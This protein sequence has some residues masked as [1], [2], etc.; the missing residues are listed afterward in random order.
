M[1]EI[2]R[3]AI[4]DMLGGMP[5]V[6]I[7]EY[8]FKDTELFGIMLPDTV[9]EIR[10]D[11]FSSADNLDYVRLSQSLE[12]IGSWAFS[13]NYELRQIELPETLRELDDWAF[14]SSALESVVVPAGTESVGTGTF[15][16][17]GNLTSVQLP[18]SCAYEEDSFEGIP[19]WG[20]SF[21]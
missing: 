8:A 14:Y 19:G 18:Q 21:Y 12:Y 20:I 6:A 11:A 16:N 15:K 4:P 13:F 1:G 17:C 3:I 10:W 9:K 7:G 2:S 5:V